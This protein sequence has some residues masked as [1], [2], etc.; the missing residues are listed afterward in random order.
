M[1]LFHVRLG[2]A[3]LPRELPP[4][5]RPVCPSCRAQI[6]GTPRN[7]DLCPRC[8]SRYYLR[9][10]PNSPTLF[11]LSAAQAAAFDQNAPHPAAPAAPAQGVQN[12]RARTPR[13]R[14]ALGIDKRRFNWVWVHGTAEGQWR[15]LK[16]S[17]TLHAR[18][19]NWLLYRNA[20]F[21]MAEVRR[22]Q[23]RLR[24]A[25]ELYLEVWYLDLNGPRDCWGVSGV[26][27][28]YED[29]PF[30]PADGLT[31]PVV[32][33]W[34]NRIAERL[35]VDVLQLEREFGQIATRLYQS[36]H[37]PVTPR[38]AWLIARRDVAV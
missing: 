27:R 33:R 34:V 4:Q 36:M 25:L 15:Q 23:D 37:L 6:T 20:R 16:R 13:P 17:L 3:R 30:Q 22:K 38:D 32:A 35:Y 14:N 5:R 11:L 8:G 18:D 7:G 31:T 24:E 9:K 26:R 12:G 21:E 2:R 28:I 10:K 29:A 19:G 1:N